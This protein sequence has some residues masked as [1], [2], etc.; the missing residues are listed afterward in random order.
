MMTILLIDPAKEMDP[1]GS[2]AAEATAIADWAT[3]REL[4]LIRAGRADRHQHLGRLLGLESWPMPEMATQQSVQTQIPPAPSEKDWDRLSRLG[5]MV[6]AIS[7]DIVFRQVLTGLSEAGLARRYLKCR[8][9][10]Y[11][12]DWPLENLMAELEREQVITAAYVRLRRLT[13]T[14]EQYLEEQCV[15]ETALDP[16]AREALEAARSILE[17][18]TDLETADPLLRA[19]SRLEAAFR[20]NP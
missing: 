9:T 7:E 16:E 2:W 3:E 10:R 19:H 11:N 5:F 20:L 4:R 8:L 13:L 12:A 14:L 15:A 18:R 6:L 17:E 1:D